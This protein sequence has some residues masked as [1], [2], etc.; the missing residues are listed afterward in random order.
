MRFFPFLALLGALA[1][2]GPG[3]AGG[4][5]RAEEGVALA[6]VYDTSGSM[7]DGVPDRS[8]QPS[9][10][11]KIAN[12]ALIEVTRQ[13]EAFA[14]NTAGGETRRVEAGLI[15]FRGEHPQEALKFG[16]FDPAALRQWATRFATPNG[17]TPLGES[18]E[19][20]ARAVFK[21]ALA[22]KHVLVITDGLNTAGPRP[23][24]V[25]PRLQK[26]AND[27]QLS[28]AVHFVAFD[29]DAKQFDSLKRL[30]TT[31]VGA[32]DESQ[33]QSR[34]Q[35]ILQEKILL[36]EEETPKSK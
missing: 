36:E 33:L 20:G 10:K 27:R 14:T 25:L 22:R 21:S 34:L 32:A 13:I 35:Y 26:E 3:P 29:V 4:A 6:I 12:R 28:L 17:N 30:G 8:G 1:L 11:F 7:R 18:L 24:N 19:A 9:P 5:A 15:T 16:P 31:V 2:G 23:E